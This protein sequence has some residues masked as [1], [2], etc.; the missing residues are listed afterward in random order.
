MKLY[1]ILYFEFTCLIG[2]TLPS[3]NVV[4]WSSIIL[5]SFFR[6]FLKNGLLS[7]LIQFTIFTLPLFR[8][9]LNVT[10]D[11]PNSFTTDAVRQDS[12]PLTMH[13]P[14]IY[15]WLISILTEFLEALS[16]TSAVCTEAE[17]HTARERNRSTAAIRRNVIIN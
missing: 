17:D 14:P 9:Y 11:T 15:A 5:K 3:S 2:S 4:Y 10:I 16:L 6:T 8:S 13:I 1:V 12:S 7:C